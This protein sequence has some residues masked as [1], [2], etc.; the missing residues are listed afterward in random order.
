MILPARNI[1][2]TAIQCV[3]GAITASDGKVD[4]IYL[5]ANFGQAS[6][7]PPRVIINPN[8]LYPIESVIRS[9]RRFAIN[10]LRQDQRGLARRLVCIRRRQPDKASVAGASLKRDRHG[11]PF[12]DDCLRTLFCEVE[13]VLDSG[14]HTVMIARVLESRPYTGSERT[15]P[16]LYREIAGTQSEY[17]GLA[18]AVRAVLNGA[19]ARNLLLRLKQRLRPA[20]PA[21]L[22]AETYREGGQTEE[23]IE[24]IT[25]YGTSDRGRLIAPP[26]S[27]P[28]LLRRRVAVCVVGVGQWGAFHCRLFRQASPLVDLYVCGRQPDRLSRLARAVGAKDVIFGLERAVEDPRL[29]ALSLALP[30]DLHA[31]AATNSLQSGK[32]VLVEKPIAN[33]LEEADRMIGAARESG[34]ILMVAEDMHF[35]PA[36]RE[37]A[38]AIASG[39]IGEPLYLVVHAGGIMRPSG[40]K[41][42]KDRMGGGVLMD[43]GVHYIRALRLLLGE[44][45]RAFATRAMQI[46][47]KMSGEDSVQLLFE[48]R[49]GWQAHMLLS[50][51]TIRGHSPDIVIAGE[52]GTLYLWPGARYIDLFPAAPRT[53]PALLSYVRPHWLAQALARPSMQRVRRPVRDSDRT[54]YLTEVREFLAA[55]SEDRPPVT[56]PEDARRDLEIVLRCYDALRSRSWTNIRQ[57]NA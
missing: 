10:V 30:H 31:S 52:R 14:D 29:Q 9:S 15:M 21:S 5:S 13:Q 19:G 17:P 20:P 37:A 24:T 23:E 34:R 32:H 55:V 6:L 7:D 57:P 40:W 18:R 16:L 35:R 45:D 39:D 3:C 12:L 28:A 38:K 8:R 54:G 51:S 33:T 27:P 41:A 25:Q 50:W 4:E 26:P 42:E 22:A 47:T 36:V 1:W 46:N 11:I 56:P 53:L 43:I 44:P 48:S 49:F 2:D